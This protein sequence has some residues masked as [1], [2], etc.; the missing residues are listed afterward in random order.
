MSD[1]QISEEK[2]QKLINI[3]YRMAGFGIGLSGCVVVLIIGVS[4]LLGLLFDRT[5][6]SSRHLFTFIFVLISL[7]LNVLALLW[8]VRFTTNRFKP[9]QD[10]AQNE[11]QEDDNSVGS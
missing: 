11:I 3:T 1:A 5:F 10:A 6:G 4:I 8:V 7:P 9:T 2:R